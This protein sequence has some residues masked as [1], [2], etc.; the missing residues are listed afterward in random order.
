MVVD[1]NAKE[2]KTV[3]APYGSLSGNAPKAADTSGQQSNVSTN[4]NN[5]LNPAQPAGSKSTTKA[6]KASAPDEPVN[7]P[8]VTHLGPDVGAVPPPVYSSPSVHELAVQ[9]AEE[10]FGPDAHNNP[11]FDAYVKDRE[12]Q[13]NATLERTQ[14]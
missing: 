13:M 8:L 4:R 1:P 3:T 2:A 9:T 6:S 10:A 11:G 14:G 12:A 7:N 5:N